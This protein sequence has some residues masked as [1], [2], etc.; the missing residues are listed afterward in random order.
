MR[1]ITIREAY[2]WIYDDPNHSQGLT[3]GEWEELLSYLRQKYENENVVEYANKKIRFINLVGVLQLKKVRIEIL[4]KISVSREDV[5]M[6]RL[7]LLNMLAVT[8][9]LP[10]HIGEKTLSAY[11]KVNILHVLAHIFVTELH[12]ALK[13]GLYREYYANAENMN[14]LK[15]R[16]LVSKHIQKNAFIPVNAFC[17]FDELSAN[18]PFNQTLKAAV[19]LIYPYV[20]QANIKV[21]MLTIFELLKDV[22]EKHISH[23]VLE[24][25]TCNRQNKHF[26][27]ALQLAVAILKSLSMNTKQHNQI[28]FSFL[29]KMNDLF[30]GYI[31][32]VLKKRMIPTKSKVDAQHTEKRLLRNVNSGRENILLKPD[33]VISVNEQGNFIPKIIIDTKWKTILMNGR[34]LYQQSDI[35]Q[36]YAYITS[37]ESAERCIILYP[38]T[39]EGLLPKWLVPNS[40]PEKYIEVRTVRLDAVGH[41]LEDVEGI[42]G[43]VVVPEI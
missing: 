20:Q 35:Y 8:K 41:T 23:H 1:H 28:A 17:E 9:K 14:R 30:E 4:P 31:G 25:I 7:V 33:F 5:E 24:T 13:R 38:H 32:E 29:F 39:E 2:D 3:K 10:I 42:F 15:G 16:L 6:D 34:V 36:M 18:I 19:K 21:Q 26:E 43:G 11:K 40:S 37:Y 27:T 22:E 12:K